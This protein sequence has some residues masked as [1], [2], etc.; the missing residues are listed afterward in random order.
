MST[1]RR[2]ALIGLVLAAALLPSSIA[3]GGHSVLDRGAEC[4]R[5][6]EEAQR[7]DMESFRDFDAEA[8]RAVHDA[9]AISIFPSGFTAVGIDDI[10]SALSGHF[11]NRNA[12][13][14]WTELSRRVEGCRTA[15]IRYDATYDIPSIGF[16]QRAIT[17]VTYIFTHGR[18]LG[19]LDQGTLLEFDPG[20]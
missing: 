20:S 18:W 4:A 10:M 15:V 3:L 16:H 12:V 11:T 5:K 1:R 9:D 8:F 6:F 19:I 2:T 14:S 13:W 7:Q 17:V